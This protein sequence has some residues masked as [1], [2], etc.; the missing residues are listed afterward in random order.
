[1]NKIYEESHH[2]DFYGELLTDTQ[3][4][5]FEEVVLNDCS[6]GEVAEE[7]GISRQG[8]HDMIKRTKLL[9]VGYEEKL[10]LVSKFLK[11]KEDVDKIRQLTDNKEIVRLAQEI[12]DEL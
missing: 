9:L 3:K 10:G 1:M 6:L 11:I 2:N 12:I 8:V 5:V 7:R 4:D